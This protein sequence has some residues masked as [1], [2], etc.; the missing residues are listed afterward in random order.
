MQINVGR[1]WTI[2]HPR[3]ALGYAVL[4]LVVCS[5]GVG[6]WAVRDPA[7]V[8]R[9]ERA[10]EAF[11]STQRESA[12]EWRI[13]ATCADEHDQ[14]NANIRLTLAGSRLTWASERGTATYLRCPVARP[15][16]TNG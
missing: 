2:A 11:N 13:R 14:W 15:A 5:A 8:Q 4:A 16:Y 7:S 6:G 9:V 1:R 10:R 12:N 3:L